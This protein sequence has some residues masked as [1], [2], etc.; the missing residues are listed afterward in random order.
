VIISGGLAA[1]RAGTPAYAADTVQCG[2]TGSIFGAATDG[3]FFVYPVS[4]PGS[5]TAAHGNRTDIG[6]AWQ[7]YG[8][9]LG[10]PGGRVYGIKAAGL[11]RYRWLGSAWE[12]PGQVINEGFDQYATAAYRDKI[13]VDET[14][15]FYLIDGGGKLRMYRYDEAT[16]TWPIFGR[17]LDRGWDRYNLIVAAGPGVLYGR[18][19]DG[20]LFRHRYDAAS[21]RWILRDKQVGSGWQIFPKGIFSV[22]GDT[23]FGI[24]A[25]G[26]LIN[27]RYREDNNTWPV[28]GHVLGT[29]GWQNY[30]NVLATTNTCHLNVSYTPPR[31]NTP[32]RGFT[33]TAA[34]QSAPPA[35]QALG[36]I[37][38][39]YTDNIGRLMH[40]R[41]DP[42][43]LSSIVWTA[44]SGED[45]FTGTPAI[46]G[47]AQG[48]V[49]ILGH[50]VGSNVWRRGQTAAGSPGWNAWV[51]LGGM[52]ASEPV[53]TKLTDTSLV[54]FALDA[55]GQV[56]YAPQDGTDGDLMAWRRPTGAGL[57]GTGLA[58]LVV[59]PGA[60]R[61]ATLVAVGTGGTLQAAT[62]RDGTLS[63]WAGLG[64]TG[65]AGTP[66]I[67]AMPGRKLRVFARDGDGHVQTQQQS[68]AGV[69]PGTWTPV[70]DL[71]TAGAPAAVLHPV[72]GRVEVVARTGDGALH[73]IRETAQGSGEW[74]AWVDIPG[75]GFTAATDPTIVTYANSSGPTYLFVARDADNAQHYWFP[76]S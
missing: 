52:M 26:E 42:E 22:G 58:D 44:V 60:D 51:D 50:N 39:A 75:G 5:A 2:A 14:G 16:K 9:V 25:T 68:D 55:A 8:R 40:G 21:Q 32:V 63:A 61:A 67:V 71:V 17:V 43:A 34:F 24:K 38:Y 6:N 48:L 4:A 37:E 62:Y 47:N 13:T 73:A 19:G 72:L 33:R 18:A 54:A 3:N 49:Q 59:T 56:W 57:S 53:L 64:G 46:A 41:Q 35:G 27:Y 69:F 30:A 66:A 31:P 45:A 29:A 76:P 7:M 36:T 1:V 12:G 23:L 65:F 20:R 70:G 11:F 74:G 15:D 10:G 28:A